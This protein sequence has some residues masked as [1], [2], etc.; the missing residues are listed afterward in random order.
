MKPFV[1]GG[2][3]SEVTPPSPIDE[4]PAFGPAVRGWSYS[5]RWGEIDFTVPMFDGFMKRWIPDLKTL[6]N[7]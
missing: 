3:G 1:E 7:R 2:D 4:P 5:P 6:G